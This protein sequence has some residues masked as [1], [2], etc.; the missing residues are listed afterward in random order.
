MRVS[1][2]TEF[3]LPPLILWAGII[4]SKLGKAS[5]ALA[6]FIHIE[7]SSIIA[8]ERIRIEVLSEQSKTAI[9]SRDPE[10]GSEYIWKLEQSGQSAG[11][12]ETL[13]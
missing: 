6:I 10:Q 2:N 11:E 12:S 3:D 13:L 5:Q 9:A 4:F 7:Q 8:L 1:P